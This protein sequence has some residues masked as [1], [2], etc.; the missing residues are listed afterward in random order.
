MLHATQ[1]TQRIAPPAT[2]EYLRAH[3][4][5][6]PQITVWLGSH[7]RARE[8]PV[9]SI[10]IQRP[11]ALQPLDDKLAP[12]AN[13]GFL[14]FLAVGGV[15]FVVVGHGYRNR[16]EVS[17]EGSF[18]EALIPIWP[19]PAPVVSWPPKYMMDREFID[20]LTESP[21]ALTMQVWP[22]GK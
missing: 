2:Y 5:P 1:G 21:S 14:C 20:I 12:H 9:N 19:N 7:Y 18:D 17:Y 15:S 16:T 8:D 22:A 10:F 11:L 3:G 13:F 6:P 4:Q